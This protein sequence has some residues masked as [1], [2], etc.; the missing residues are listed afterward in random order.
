MRRLL[1]F[2]PGDETLET[3]PAGRRRKSH[4]ARRNRN[5]EAL[6]YQV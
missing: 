2:S 1:T 5:H 3:P 6:W 4:Y